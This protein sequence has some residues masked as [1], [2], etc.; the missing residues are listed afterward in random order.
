M[1][2][3]YSLA[4]LALVSCAN[5]PNPVTKPTE[6]VSNGLEA[7]ELAVGEC[8]I[9]LW[10]LATPPIFTYFHKSG[11]GQAKVFLDTKEMVL[12]VPEEKQ[13][14]TD[15]GKF[16]YENET[17]V[18]QH[19]RVKGQYGEAMD[20]GRRIPSGSIQFINQDGWREITPV[21]GIYVCR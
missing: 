4:T 11:S 2:V 21:S 14:I 6:T 3:F 17:G 10:T 13:V 8:G 19:I 20:G 16:V 5:L 1:R 15:F 7:Q 18:A 9:F 12:Q